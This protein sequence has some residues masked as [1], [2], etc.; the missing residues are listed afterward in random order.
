MGSGCKV[1]VNEI[2][3][4]SVP[5]KKRKWYV[6]FTGTLRGTQRMACQAVIGGDCEVRT[7]PGA[8]VAVENMSWEPDA[9]KWAWHDRLVQE[10][11]KKKAKPVAEAQAAPAPAAPAQA[12]PA[13]AAPA[14]AAPAPAQ[15]PAPVAAPAQAADAPE[16]AGKPKRKPP[17]DT[18]SGWDE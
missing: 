10:K 11:K 12:A 2:E 5:A 16:P 18:D 7:Q 14:P 8:F 9:R 3:K 15:A 17:S 6:P 1:W 4:G 13:Q